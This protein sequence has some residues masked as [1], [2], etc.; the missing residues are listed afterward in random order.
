MNKLFFIL[1]LPVFI[2][3]LPHEV[4]AQ[5]NNFPVF[6]TTSW[7]AEHIN[8]PSLV[9]LHVAPIRRDYERG[10]ISGARFLW[11]GWIYMSNP[12]LSYELLPA[13]QLNATL[14]MLGVSND[15]R[16]IL[17]GMSGNVNQVARIFVTLDYLGMGDRTSILDGGFDAWKIEG[18]PVTKEL[19]VYQRGSFSPKLIPTAIVD[20][21][22][23]KSGLH[24]SNI[25]IIDARAPMFYNGA[26][27]GGYLRAGAIPTAKNIFA[28]S[29]IDST[30]K[31]IPMTRIAEKFDSAGV[32][33][34]NDVI[35]YCHS[36][37]SA[38]VV[39]TA[40]RSLGYTPHLYDGSFEDWSGREDLPMALPAKQDSVKR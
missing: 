1:F 2:V 39:Y 14:E 11:N 17:C 37:V 33:K 10:H 19:P 22:F 25:S 36:G 7:L 20:A 4:N 29:L 35:V 3:L 9:I 13:E 40:A 28:G 8:D 23:V 26:N 31:M 5:P 12:E 32:K 38:C 16:I 27:S 15:S 6:V 18:K 30:N 24:K 34:G 21:E